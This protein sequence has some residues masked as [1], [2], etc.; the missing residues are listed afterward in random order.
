LNL[1]R[2][3]SHRLTRITDREFDCEVARVHDMTREQPDRRNQ[4]LVRSFA[5][6]K[7]AVRRTLSLDLYD[8]QLLA[9]LVM[10]HGAVAEMATGEGKTLAA[11][12]PAFYWSL[13]G[14]GVHV[15]TA[16]SYLAE[17]DAVLLR[18]AFEVLQCTVGLLTD[19][20]SDV[21]KRRSYACDIT[22]G[23]GYEF[24][25][26]YLRDQHDLAQLSRLPFGQ[27]TRRGLRFDD[28]GRPAAR[29]RGL[30]FAIVDELDSVL[31]DEARTPL[32]LALGGEEPAADRAVVTAAEQ[33][34][35]QL[36]TGQHFLAVPVTRTC[37]LTPAGENAIAT[38]RPTSRF[39]RPWRQYVETALQA[40]HFFQRDVHY[41]VVD[42]RVQI[43]DEQSGRIMPE[44]TWSDG[45]QQAIQAR[46]GLAILRD[47][48]SAGR[49]SRQ[50]YF[51]KY[52]RLAGM[53]GTAIEAAG[54]LRK[55]FALNVVE[56]PTHR[57]LCRQVWPQRTFVDGTAK[58]RAIVASI[59]EIHRT[60]RPLLIGCRTIENSL[61]LAD[62]L[63]NNRIAFE[64]LNGCQSR[65]E[66]EVVAVAGSR[67]AITIAT[68]MAG[69]GTD[70][71]LSPA[72]IDLGGLHVIGAERH[73]A[74][75]IDRQLAGRAGRQGDPGSAQ[76][77]LSAEDD[78]IARHRPNWADIWRRK[79]NSHGEIL[80]DMRPD[81]ARLQTEIEQQHFRERV[82]LRKHD[83]WQ[84]GFAEMVYGSG[85]HSG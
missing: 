19:R 74:T 79:A 55:L 77:F 21:D 60:G 63:R 52:E 38:S 83:A 82:L 2:V 35:K 49:M 4:R 3:E 30:A 29:Q 17:R 23:S 39:Q 37:A 24:G 36:R 51:H 12:A 9:G 72:V 62:A 13:A 85:I 14:Q 50:A 78:L 54:E 5:L 6:A 15:V 68:N 66:A 34:A 48:V 67:G 41:V 61:R 64:L 73:E 32:L 31:I 76:F 57:P 18:S 43:V 20:Q 75:R 80:E 1:I 70:I 22:Y 16:N 81:I 44:R 33:V 65:H 71:R 46:E 84:A 27:V 45:L 10:A 28:G 8:E 59:Q 69:R 25:F 58:W 47:A 42:G 11:V 26:D 56:I 7:E 53:T 40:S